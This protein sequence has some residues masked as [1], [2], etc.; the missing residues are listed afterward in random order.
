VLDCLLHIMAFIRRMRQSEREVRRIE[1]SERRQEKI[2]EKKKAHREK[3]SQKGDPERSRRAKVEL[4]KAIDA[5]EQIQADKTR[6]ENRD[7]I[8]AFVEYNQPVEIAEIAK[9]LNLPADSIERH[10][11]VLQVAKDEDG[12]LYSTAVKPSGMKLEDKLRRLKAKISELSHGLKTKTQKDQGEEVVIEK[13]KEVVEVNPGLTQDEL[14]EIYIILYPE[15][16]ADIERYLE[17]I[18][19]GAKIEEGAKLDEKAKSEVGVKIKECVKTVVTRLNIERFL[20]EIKEIAKAEDKRWL[21]PAM[22][23]LVAL[24]SCICYLCSHVSFFI[25]PPPPEASMDW[26]HSL[27][28]FD[29]YHGAFLWLT[30]L[31]ILGGLFLIRY[32]KIGVVILILGGVLQ[33]LLSPLYITSF[34]PSSFDYLPYPPLSL[35]IFALMPVVL[36]TCLVLIGIIPWIKKLLPKERVEKLKKKLKW[37]KVIVG[38]EYPGESEYP[39]E[40]WEQRGKEGTIMKAAISEYLADSDPDIVAHIKRICY[41]AFWI[42]SFMKR[43]KTIEIEKYPDFISTCK[44]EYRDWLNVLETS[45]EPGISDS[46]LSIYAERIKRCDV[47][48]ESLDL[49]DMPGHRE[50]IEE[51]WIVEQNKV[52][53][54]IYNVLK[55]FFDVVSVELERDITKE[56]LIKVFMRAYLEVLGDSESAPIWITIDL[57]SGGGRL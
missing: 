25:E 12:R 35:K 30:I 4:N 37:K 57:K 16:E 48:L 8:F 17:E 11:D 24:S 13:W 2:V 50:I 10:I 21:G 52:I 9:A 43:S 55:P 29:L 26:Y 31:A 41:D 51:M 38:Q 54:R 7:Q 22:C 34:Q 45:K 15:E 6:A 3:V 28:R 49:E 44:S 1:K 20:N 42:E 18:K 56:V 27:I 47:L 53:E 46:E 36:A 19:E 5:L 14:K 39:E 40:E 32:R 33:F 23:F